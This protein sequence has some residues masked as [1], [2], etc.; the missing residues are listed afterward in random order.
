MSRYL[1]D[2][3]I[4]LW[5]QSAPE[6]L[7]AETLAIVRDRANILLLSSA[8]AWEIAIKVA[9]GKLH[10]PKPPEVYLPDRLRRSG[11]EALPI[12]LAHGLAAG[13]LPG[14][15]KDPFDRMII[16]Q[17]QMLGAP[18]ITVDEAF[19]AYDVDVIQG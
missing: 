13:A 14:H 16:A 9:L 8:S 18:V 10:L 5:M 2:T 12:E 4:W 1:L 7:S 11:V 3:H 6:R 17:A 15:H 19:S